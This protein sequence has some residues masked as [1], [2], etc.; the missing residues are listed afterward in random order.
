MKI[1]LGNANRDIQKMALGEIATPHIENFRG[2]YMTDGLTA[3]GEILRP[4]YL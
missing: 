2:Y 4:E 1:L 3:T